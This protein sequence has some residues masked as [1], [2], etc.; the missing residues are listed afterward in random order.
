MRNLI[1]GSLAC[2]QGKE[3]NKQTNGVGE[4]RERESERGIGQREEEKKKEQ[5]C[6]EERNAGSRGVRVLLIHIYIN[7]LFIIL[8]GIPPR[9]LPTTIMI[10]CMRRTELER[11]RR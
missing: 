2:E 5:K 7:P 10:L 8:L 3:H 9:S 11:E 4:E 1:T 6:E